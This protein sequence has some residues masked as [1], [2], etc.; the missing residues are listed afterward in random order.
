M[1]KSLNKQKLKYSSVATIF[2]A[3]FITLI[4]LINVLFS[5]LS[6]RFPLSID[7]T[8]NGMYE[9]SEETISTLNNLTEDIQIT[10]LD[11]DDFTYTKSKYG[12]NVDA[13]YLN[14]FPEIF[15]RYESLSGGKVNV[16]YLDPYT[17][18]TAISDYTT[19]FETPSVADVIVESSKRSVLLSSTDF[20]E[21]ETKY[22]TILTDYTYQEVAGLQAEQKLTSAILYSTTDT[23]PKAVFVNGHGEQEVPAL[24]SLLV[25]GNYELSNVNLTT[26]DLPDNTILIVI[27][28]PTTDFIG[29]ELEKLDQF[30]SEGGNII[31]LA[32]PQSGTLPNLD[33]YWAEWGVRFE[34]SLV[35]DSSRNLMYQL[36]V[37]PYLQ[38]TDLTQKLV[39]SDAL[40]VTP[41]ARPITVL[42]DTDEQWRTTS[43]LLKTG[44]TSYA[45]DLTAGDISLDQ[46][47][48]DEKG[49]FNVAVITTH[50]N[51]NNEKEYSQVFFASLDF[52]SPTY[53]S[54]NTYLNQDLIV[55]VLNAFNPD[56]E[57]I[58]IN[59]KNLATDEMSVQAWQATIL[60]WALVI[61]LPVTILIIGAFV[62]IR[63]RN[64]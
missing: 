62:W 21:M 54:N 27:A 43:V 64:M 38:E 3:L 19:E 28:G 23:L 41:N 36:N 13:Q 17:N 40:A 10:V 55:T 51:I 59:S 29:I 49:P 34:N 39:S 42:W 15:S 56:T 1:K 57:S 26:D 12:E 45:K 25:S 35:M 44:D 7:L 50:D 6:E 9:L 52:V 31:Y 33:A 24:T 37:L 2:I 22:S 32:N 30:F 63:R 16:R 47:D 14:A 4:V 20:F 11:K 58:I 8:N 48:S 5:F 60:F 46:E 61:I 53:L 18:P